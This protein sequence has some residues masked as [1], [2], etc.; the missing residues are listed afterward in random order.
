MSDGCAG[1]VLLA[2]HSTPVYCL[3]T[4]TRVTTDSNAGQWEKGG[5][6]TEYEM[7]GGGG[8]EGEGIGSI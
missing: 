4:Q 2:R 7:T 5:R 1:A 8:L 6:W 3:F